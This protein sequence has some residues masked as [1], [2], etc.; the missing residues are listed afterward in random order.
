[1]PHRRGDIIAVPYEYSDLTGGKVRPALI[2]SSDSYNLAR[3]DVVA[4][5]ITSQIGNM[6][7]Y[8]HV[9]ADW[10][11]AG[12]RYPSLVRGR[13][14]TIEQTLIRRSVGRVSYQDWEKV[15]DRLVSFLLSDEG[16]VR[17]LLDHVTLSSLP[18][19]LVQALG[20]KSIHAGLRLASRD[21]QTIDLAHWRSLL[22][23]QQAP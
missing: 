1:M 3:P 7:P 16:A 17:F 10:A 6:G 11:A 21:D 23:P 19:A 18:G 5:G 12:L 15:E 2:V 20:E 8:D 22:S 14:L 4:A 9:L 13:L